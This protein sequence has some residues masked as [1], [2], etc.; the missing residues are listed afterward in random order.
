MG[1]K[2]HAAHVPVKIRYFLS[3]GI[4]CENRQASMEHGREA[5]VDRMENLF[6][7]V[8]VKAQQD[9]RRAVR[10]NRCHKKSHTR[11]G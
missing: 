11:T 1:R 6:P 7:G 10:M 9:R 4:S 5:D 2:T 8:K 3:F